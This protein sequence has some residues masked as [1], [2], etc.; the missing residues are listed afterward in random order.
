MKK[1]LSILVLLCLEKAL[2][3]QYV[4]TIKADSVKI[5]NSCD[6]AELIIENHT[7]TVPGFLFN[8]GRGR[9]EFRRAQ[10]LNDSTI[11]LGG[12]TF[13]IRGGDYSLWKIDNANNLT[14]KPFLGDSVKIGNKL[15]YVN[16]NITQTGSLFTVGPA[17][18]NVANSNLILSYNQPVNPTGTG[19]IAIGLNGLFQS[20]TTGGQNVAIGDYSMT[21]LT[22]GHG[23]VAVGPG[24]L[25]R[26]TGGIRNIALGNQAMQ[27]ATT[28][29]DNVDIGGHTSN[30]NVGNDNVFIGLG[31]VWYDGLG[32]TIGSNN[33][34]IGKRATGTSKISTND[35]N[36]VIG[37]QSFTNLTTNTTIIGHGMN[38]ALSNVFLLG[39][40]NQHILV[41]SGIDN[42]AKFQ[43]SGTGVFSDTLT[44]TTM[45]SDDNSN[46]VATTAFVKNAIGAPALSVI[47]AAV[48]DITAS[49][50]ALIRLPDLSGA[51][52]H[53][54]I[55]PSASLYT[56]QRIYLWNM[57]S[58]AN[59]WTFSTSI[60]LPNGTTSNSIAN[61]STIELISDGAVWL[62]WN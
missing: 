38:T 8:K 60:T 56:G 29:S 4:Y 46:R 41:G 48:A 36:I 47:H 28:S 37:S 19:N 15:F 14:H 55:L 42:G 18:L 44:A 21:A 33:I 26:L 40:P 52:S 51:G 13:L 16:N 61:Q 58:S 45:G 57:N 20:L 30:A 31:G 12:D 11:V 27:W 50:G 34:H 43:V 7:Q 5:T 59:S 25:Q 10:K 6:T 24:A 39:K 49:A 35:S 23:N 22:T 2:H 32:R 54:V 1:L 3:A 62:K 53:S 9:T 17:K